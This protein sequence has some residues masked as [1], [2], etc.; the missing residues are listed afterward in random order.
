LN[1]FDQ[2]FQILK[3]QFA[4][5]VCSSSYRV[6]IMKNKNYQ[7]VKDLDE[8]ENEKKKIVEQKENV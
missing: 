6:A 4:Q 3:K 2:K 8:V 5:L 7:L 1:K